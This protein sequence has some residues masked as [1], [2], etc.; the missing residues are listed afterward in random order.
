MGII[1]VSGILRSF[2]W[3]STYKIRLPIH[4]DKILGPLKLFLTPKGEK[5]DKQW[6]DSPPPGGIE[7][8]DR[9]G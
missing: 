9:S 2:L 8:F 1:S 4:S 6:F 7:P 5:N 3:S